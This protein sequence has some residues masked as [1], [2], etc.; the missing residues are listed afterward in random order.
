MPAYIILNGARDD[1]QW[2]TKT[3]SKRILN[4]ANSMVHAWKKAGGRVKDPGLRGHLL[5]SEL[6]Y[7][8]RHRLLGIQLKKSFLPAKLH[9]IAASS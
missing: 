8:Y 7:L 4:T 2:T 5:E 9:P 1:L 3:G 6:L